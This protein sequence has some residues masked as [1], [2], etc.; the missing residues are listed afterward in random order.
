MKKLLLETSFSKIYMLGVILISLL[1]IG[2]YFSYAMFTVSKEKNN[3]ISIVTGNLDYNLLVDGEKKD[4]LTLSEYE[5]TEFTITLSNPNNR[6]ARFNLY[7]IGD[8]PEDVY[9]GYVVEDSYNSAPTDAGVN[10]EK[11]G[12]SGSSAVY[13]IKVMK[14]RED[15]PTIKLGVNVGLDYNDLTV[16]NNAHSFTEYTGIP[17]GVFFD[18]NFSSERVDDQRIF[19]EDTTKLNNYIWYSGKLWRGVSIDTTDNSLKLMTTWNISAISYNEKDNTNFAGSYMEQWL[20]D[21]SVDGFLGN[22]REPDK[23]IKMDSKWNATPVS[24]FQQKPGNTNIVE[25]PVGL[26]NAYEYSKASSILGYIYYLNNSLDWWTISPISSSNSINLVGNQGEFGTGSVSISGFRPVINLKP[27]VKII[28]GDGTIDNPYRLYGDNDNPTGSLLNTRYSGEYITFGAG[29]N[30]LY[31]IVSHETEGLTKITSAEPLK[32]NSKYKTSAFG[33]SN[34]Y[35]STNTIG[36]FLNNDFLNPSNG[37]LTNADIN[38]I[39]D[40]TTWYL[41]TMS[42]GDNYRLTKYTTAT[43]NTLTSN[44]TTA[45]VG[46]LRLGELMAG[47]FDEVDNNSNY[48][49][50]TPAT[51]TNVQSSYKSSSTLST[52]PTASNGIKPAMNLKSNVVITGGDG[53]KN[54]P[55]TLKLQ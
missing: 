22:L 3:A 38:M 17:A 44:R 41:G 50:L 24:N 4:E 53:T 34:K 29:E 40:N 7:Y 45:K 11:A 2:G 23:F 35:S 9:V 37:Y 12:T 46:L 52:A 42:S 48:W 25:D 54:N 1:V 13:K 31:R 43:G 20:N 39:E 21:T 32:E 36:N 28:S 55:F 27:D 19:V 49:L 15:N 33:N 26:L 18:N 5:E 51:T 6:T 8:L 16:P 14:F 30:N 47:Q 10:L